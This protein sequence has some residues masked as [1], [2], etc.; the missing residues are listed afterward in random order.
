[1]CNSIP[2]FSSQYYSV[3]IIITIG[4]CGHYALFNIL[5]MLEMHNAETEKEMLDYIKQTSSIGSF[6]RRQV[7][8]TCGC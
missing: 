5:C 8:R 6:W 3:H 2:I 1:M 7:D 4:Y